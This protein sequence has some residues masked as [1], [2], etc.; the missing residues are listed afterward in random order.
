MVILS[1]IDQINVSNLTHFESRVYL[2][3]RNIVNIK[4]VSYLLSYTSTL[5]YCPYPVHGNR[6]PSSQEFL[7]AKG[8]S[9]IGL[10]PT[11]KTLSAHRTAPLNNSSL[12][13]SKLTT[14]NKSPIML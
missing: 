9:I 2:S 8:L 4:V 1:Q 11:A 3:S 6:N 12:Q 10:R 7:H 13:H 5:L 14:T